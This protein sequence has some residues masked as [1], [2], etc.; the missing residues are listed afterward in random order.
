M[1]VKQSVRIIPYLLECGAAGQLS[2]SSHCIHGDYPAHGHDYYEM[3]LIVSGCGQHFINNNRIPLTRGSLFL[4]TP[5]DIHRISVSGRF[6]SISIH[7]LPEAAALVGLDGVTAAYSMQLTESDYDLFFTLLSRLLREDA[8]SQPY[9]ARELMATASLML[10]HLLRC[11]H[12]RLSLPYVRG[13]LPA[14]K[15]IQQN[16]AR[17]DL[18]LSDAAQL[19]G[20][21]SCHFSATFHDVVGCRFSEY[22][23]G[24]RLH[25]ACALLANGGATVSEIAYAVGFSSLP[26]FFRA[27]RRMYACSPMEYRR[28]ALQGDALPPGLRIIE[29]PA[30]E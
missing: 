21:S 8:S 7:C 11:G 17:S 23:M 9:F 2:I 18:R 27:F 13:M 1:P 26:H 24:C 30:T 3:E 22:L 20:L 14:L 29:P 16:F 12:T 10:V 4:L 5:G 25:R 15:Y 28:R 19:C 6:D